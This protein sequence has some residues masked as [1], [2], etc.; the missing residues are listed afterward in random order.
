MKEASAPGTSCKNSEWPFVLSPL[1]SIWLVSY[2]LPV[3]QCLIEE[4]G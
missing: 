4:V 2:A 3:L 1:I